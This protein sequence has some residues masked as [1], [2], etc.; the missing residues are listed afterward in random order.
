MSLLPVEPAYRLAERAEEQ[1]WLVTSLWSEQA[2][3]IIGGYAEEPVMRR[4]GLPS[5]ILL[6]SRPHELLIKRTLPSH[7]VQPR[8]QFRISFPAWRPSGSRRCICLFKSLSLRLQ[9]RA[10]VKI[11][12]VQTFMA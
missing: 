10:R 9:I 4:N 7:R 2:V 5:S 8:Q 11:R 3:G 12:C 6:I 1:R